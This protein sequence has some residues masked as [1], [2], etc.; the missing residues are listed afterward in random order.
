ME[1]PP[2]LLSVMLPAAEEGAMGTA[3]EKRIAGRV[4]TLYQV[5][6]AVLLSIVMPCKVKEVGAGGGGG[7]EAGLD[8]FEQPAV[9]SAIAII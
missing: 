2:L 1:L 7:G 3:K 4:L 6:P 8:F 5:D 9:S